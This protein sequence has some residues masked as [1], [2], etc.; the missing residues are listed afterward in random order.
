MNQ[1]S[2]P[3]NVAVLISG[4]GSNMQALAAQAHHYR[5]SLVAANKPAAGLD[6]AAQAGI[7]TSLVN[8]ADHDSKANHEA[9]LAAAIEA[10]NAQ[11]ICLAGYMAVLSATF[12]KRFSGRIIN[13]HPSLLPDYKGLHTHQR[14]LADNKKLHGVSVHLVTPELDDGAVIAQMQLPVLGSDTE[15]SLSQRVLVLEHL[16]YPMVVN[17]LASGALQLGDGV[18]QWQDKSCAKTLTLPEGCHLIFG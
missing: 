9:A 2:S 8:R 13:I 1:A 3:L 15:D 11:W 4:R 7:N 14:A 10:S 5:I 12:I 17:A 16:L 6:I 18:V